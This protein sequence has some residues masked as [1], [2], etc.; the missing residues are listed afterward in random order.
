MGSRDI[1]LRFQHKFIQIIFSL[2]ILEILKRRDVEHNNSTSSL[3]LDQRYRRYLFIAS[4]ENR[5]N[6]LS[7]SRLSSF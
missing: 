6:F 2:I 7:R 4:N 5:T 3:P 1:F